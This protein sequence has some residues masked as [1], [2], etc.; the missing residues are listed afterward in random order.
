MLRITLLNPKGGCG[1]TTIATNLASYFAGNG[2]NT[3]LFDFDSQGSSTR[4]LDVR[5]PEL[6][7]IHG[8]PA[9]RDT[10][11]ATR[12]WQLRVPTGTDRVVVDTPASVSGP[13]F[14]E[15][16]RRS[17]RILIPLLASPIDLDAFAKFMPRL[18]RAGRVRSGDV[19]VGVIINRVRLGTRYYKTLRAQ[20]DETLAQGP[21]E[22]LTALRDTQ[23]YVL[24]GERGSGL[25]ELQSSRTAPDLAAWAPILRWFGETVDEPVGPGDKSSTRSKK[26]SDSGPKQHSLDLDAQR[27]GQRIAAA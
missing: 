4:W 7:S 25:A 11:N 24:A 10:G 5:P 9:F 18:A 13:K 1:K 16:I 8:V 15:L 27:R 3:V 12:A 20:L 17:D 14:D 6:A 2:R 26:T 23:N 19:K 22:L 21:F